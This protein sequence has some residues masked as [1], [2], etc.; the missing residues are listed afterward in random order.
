MPSLKIDF[1]YQGDAVPNPLPTP[2]YAMDRTQP[3]NVVFTV[4][5]SNASHVGSVFPSTVADPCAL[6][7]VDVTAAEAVDIEVFAARTFT[8]SANSLPYDRA[9]KVRI[10]ITEAGT[11][12]CDFKPFTTKPAP[13]A[14]TPKS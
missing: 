9:W 2:P 12:Y 8:I 10:Y 1:L 7:L 4:E 5:D 11:R 13:V 14:G 6:P 3:I